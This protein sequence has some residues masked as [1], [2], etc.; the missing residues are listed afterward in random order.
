VKRV[1]QLIVRHYGSI[2]ENDIRLFRK[3]FVNGF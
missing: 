2:H 3:L 1:E